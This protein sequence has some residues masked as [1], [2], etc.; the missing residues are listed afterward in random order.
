MCDEGEIENIYMWC[1]V[2]MYVKS[3][4]EN[5]WGRVG[6]RNQNFIALLQF[7]VNRLYS[8]DSVSNSYM[9]DTFFTLRWL[10]P[11]LAYNLPPLNARSSVIDFL[12]L[13][14]YINNLNDHVRAPSCSVRTQFIP[15]VQSSGAYQLYI[16]IYVCVCL[17]VHLLVCVR[18][19]VRYK[20]FVL[21]LF[22]FFDVSH[23]HLPLSFTSDT[24]SFSLLTRKSCA[25]NRVWSGYRTSS[26]SIV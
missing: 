23:L 21:V 10:D 25:F 11:R 16:Y 18:G 5:Q 15:N 3:H 14:L 19:W 22:Y 2:S 26:S 13:I 6:H 1:V 8:L 20:A 12:H 9:L 4:R 17:C 24:S 7:R